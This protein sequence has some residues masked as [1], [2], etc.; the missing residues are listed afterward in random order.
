MA[1]GDITV[2]RFLIKETFSESKMS[3]FMQEDSLFKHKVLFITTLNDYNLN[4]QYIILKLISKYNYT[5]K[6]LSCAPRNINAFINY[7]CNNEKYKETKLL[8]RIMTKFHLLA[9]DDELKYDIVGALIMLIST[10]FIIINDNSSILF[11]RNYKHTKFAKNL[12]L[13]PF[14]LK[15]EM[16]KFDNDPDI[17][18]PSCGNL[19]DE[20]V[21]NQFSIYKYSSIVKCIE[22]IK[23]IFYAKT[24]WNY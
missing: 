6:L 7:F 13:Y 15:I 1:Y 2:Y 22:D 24:F 19:T 16:F 21:I 20:N 18:I 4:Q 12:I 9:I 5:L 8:G 3:H 17:L 11:N 14:S 23:S 10:K